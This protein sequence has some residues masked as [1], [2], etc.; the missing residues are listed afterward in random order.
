MN[1]KIKIG[2][3]ISDYSIEALQ[4]NHKDEVVMYA[5]G[6]VPEGAVVD[7][8]IVDVERCAKELKSIVE[9]VERDKN[10]VSLEEIGVMI[11][12]PESKLMTLYFTIPN[13]VQGAG[14]EDYVVNKASETIPGNMDDLYYS[15]IVIKKGNIKQAVFLGVS[16]Q[17]VVGYKEM[18]EKAGVKLQHVGSELFALQ[19]A[20]LS[21]KRTEKA[22]MIVDMGAK[23]TSVGIFDKEDVPHL[24]V[25]VHKG[26]VDVTNQIANAL[27]VSTM[28]AEEIKKTT[29]KRGEKIMEGISKAVTSYTDVL[30]DEIGKAASYHNSKAGTHV[31][32]IVLC[33]GGSLMPEVLSA[34][35]KGTEI[36]TEIGDPFVNISNTHLFN[37]EIEP[38]L[39]SGV[40]GLGLIGSR[41]KSPV[42]NFLSIKEH[43][44]TNSKQDK[45][46]LNKVA[47][48]VSIPKAKKTSRVFYLS[49]LF[50]IAT[51]LLLFWVIIK[52]L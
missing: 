15:H 8:V 22:S 6:R 30:I 42:I 35:E 10:T 2:I 18:C 1:T 4:L 51:L 31:E 3:D 38:V 32:N 39:F 52:Y 45:V 50:V 47:Q 36:K 19:R 21:R 44:P 34:I 16:K 20:I 37:K 9:Q 46:P 41:S 26:G 13:S 28:E 25:V 43:K 23:T 12:V 24:S 48:G 40:V 33:G 14:V 17:V 49:I 29:L 11:S 27:K 5:R 7:G